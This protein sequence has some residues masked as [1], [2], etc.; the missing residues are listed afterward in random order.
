MSDAS[1]YAEYALPKLYIRVAY[2]ISCAIH[3]KGKSAEVGGHVVTDGRGLSPPAS[4][5]HFWDRGGIGMDRPSTFA[6]LRLMI[7]CPSTIRQAQRYQLPKEPSSP[8]TC[9]LPRWQ[10][11]SQ[12]LE[13]KES[14]LT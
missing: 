12:S 14:L 4:S 13:S 3:A 9:N 5:V 2:C 6:T 1:V 10:G 8:S 11:M 7:S